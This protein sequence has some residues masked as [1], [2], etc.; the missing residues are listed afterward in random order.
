MT[1]HLS[2]G[3]TPKQHQLQ[4]A[5]VGNVGGEVQQ[6]FSAPPEG[7]GRAESVTVTRQRHRADQWDRELGQA[8][9]KHCDELAE[10]L[11][12]YVPGFVEDQ[13]DAMEKRLQRG[14]EPNGEG[15]RPDQQ[16]QVQQPPRSPEGGV[17]SR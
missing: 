14:A 13:V 9:A 11:Q 17:S 12:Q 15:L 2:A 6:I 1:F 4:R 16:A 8:S 7:N 5:R 3:H 10:W